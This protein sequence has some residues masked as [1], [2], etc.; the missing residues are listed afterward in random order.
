[1]CCSFFHSQVENLQVKIFAKNWLLW[2]VWFKYE[3]RNRIVI[4]QYILFFSIA[5]PNLTPF[6]ILLDVLEKCSFLERVSII[7]PSISPLIT[8]NSLYFSQRVL[9]FCENLEKLVC[10]VFVLNCPKTHCA[11][12]VKLVN[13][14]LI[15]KRQC[16]RLDI[17][18]S[19]RSKLNYESKV[20]PLIHKSNL[21]FNSHVAVI[22]FDCTTPFIE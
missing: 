14:N 8:W 16:L 3:P 13:Q 19:T 11:N 1:M 7:S 12:A 20:L 17:F 18:Q 4:N 15:A 9:R 10:F 21:S 6:G 22:P 5:Q 2:N